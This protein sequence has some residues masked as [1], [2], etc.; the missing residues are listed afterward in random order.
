[1]RMHVKGFVSYASGVTPFLAYV[2]GCIICVTNSR[3]GMSQT[4]LQALG[5]VITGVPT[6]QG[7]LLCTIMEI[8]A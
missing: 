6:P 1:M 4:M 5:V 7:I 3:S 2:T 8:E